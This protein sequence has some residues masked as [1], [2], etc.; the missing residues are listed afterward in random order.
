MVQ[1]LLISGTDTDIGKTVV[2]SALL[3]Y[4]QA[5]RRHERVAVCKPLQS[6]SGDRELYST[7]FSLEQAPHLLNPLYYSLPLAPPLAAI[8]SGQEIDLGKAWQTVQTLQSEFDW[9]FIEALGSLGSPITHEL[10]VA[11]LA[12]DWH[13]PLLLVVPVRLGCIGQ[14]V[15]QVALARQYHLTLKGIILNC[16]EPLSDA[17]IDQWA[18]PEL[19]QSLTQVP[20]LGTIPYLTTAQDLQ[21]LAAAAAEL[22]LEALGSLGYANQTTAP[23]NSPAAS[24]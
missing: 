7:L 2:T 6:G 9:V 16:L 12:R 10:I 19:L 14:A 13:L 4:W 18:A 3:A 8:Q 1:T 23:P 15:A 17:E 5:Y 22:D 20:I 24:H 11:D 21:C